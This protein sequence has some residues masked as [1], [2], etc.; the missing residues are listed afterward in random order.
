MCDDGGSSLFDNVPNEMI[1]YTASWII[2]PKEPPTDE[3]MRYL[4]RFSMT[5][6]RMFSIITR[7]DFSCDIWSRVDI[8]RFIRLEH[9]W[10]RAKPRKIASQ[11]AVLPQI[12]WCER[13]SISYQATMPQIFA[14]ISLMPNINKLEVML[15]DQELGDSELIK[16]V[17]SK[18]MVNSMNPNQFL[19][20][21]GSLKNLESLN[22][23]DNRVFQIHP[24]TLR[25]LAL[26]VYTFFR[27]CMRAFYADPIQY[28]HPATLRDLTLWGINMCTFFGECMKPFESIKSL[29]LM[30]C[31]GISDKIQLFPSIT[32]LVI[33][34]RSGTL[35][36]KDSQMIW[37]N[38]KL[39]KEVTMITM[40]GS[41]LSMRTFEKSSFTKNLTKLHLRVK[42]PHD[43]GIWEI[44]IR[45]CPNLI[46]LYMC[47][48]MQTPDDIR[49]LTELKKLQVL[50]VNCD[51]NSERLS[52]AFLEFGESDGIALRKFELLY[53][54]LDTTE[55]DLTRFMTSHRFS[56]LHETRTWIND[57][58]WNLINRYHLFVV[59]EEEK[60]KFFC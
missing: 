30:S 28:C 53:S 7:S 26:N 20:T 36:L 12:R 24:A 33:E 32:S 59:K 50:G 58:S 16:A 44:V 21:I 22:I 41:W 56:Q 34:R 19:K 46:E 14:L 48:P 6:K 5:C 17:G 37:E 13:L 42:D 4:M 8:A 15:C 60:T 35:S 51:P 54:E 1:A 2:M 47:S 29:S 27:K 45:C 57:D 43:H 39:L 10:D 49:S 40:A 3:A 11:L 25:G 18:L 23:Y 9:G 38:C 52:S 55:F 31:S